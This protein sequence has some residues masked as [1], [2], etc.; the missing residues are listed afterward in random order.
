[1]L[2]KEFGDCR[3]PVIILLHGGGLSWWSWQKQIEELQKKYY[4]V[5]P[6]IDGHGEDCKTEFTSIEKAAGKIIDYIKDKHYGRV[7]AIC[8]LSIGAQIVV[9]VL[10]RER[11]ISEYAVVESALLYPLKISVALA[12][13]AYNLFFGLIKKRWYAKLQAKALMVPE[14][15]FENYYNDSIRMSKESLIN[16]TKSNGSYT[17]PEGMSN[18]AA[19]TLILV[20]EKELPI[21]KKSAMY[22]N[23]IVEGSKLKI[24]EKSRH[25]EISLS[26]PEK[27]LEIL[28]QFLRRNPDESD[29]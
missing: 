28:Q 21:M 7:Y 15:L 11:N 20:G 8:G 18:T 4:I 9:E 24:I 23:T 12:V 26:N 27:Y 29:I 1:M 19:R 22:L 5:T 17:V 3:L 2:I 14:L 6:I 25:G 16:M 10:A 13:P